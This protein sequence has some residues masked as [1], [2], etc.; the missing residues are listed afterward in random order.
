MGRVRD[1]H[2]AERIHLS[3]REFDAVRRGVVCDPE[4]V[5]PTMN[6]LPSVRVRVMDLPERI[7]L[8]AAEGHSVTVLMVRDPQRVVFGHPV[9]HPLSVYML[10]VADGVGREVPGR[11][12]PGKR[13][14]RRLVRETGVEEVPVAHRT[15]IA[16]AGVRRNSQEIRVKCLRN[17]ANRTIRAAVV[18]P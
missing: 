15:A 4:R 3:L 13:I 5:E 17:P 12:V 18:A 7:S 10:H 8:A 16:Q 6:Q 2:V 14:D 9:V 1:H 11:V